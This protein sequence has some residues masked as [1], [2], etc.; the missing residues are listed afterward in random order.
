MSL[1]ETLRIPEASISNTTSIWGTPRGAGGIPSKINRPNVLLSAA[2][3]RS[4]WR[5][6]ISTEV[7][8]SAAVEKIWDLLVGIVVFLSIRGVITPPNV[9]RPRVRGVTSKSTTSLTSPVK[10]PPWIAAPM[11]TTSSGLTLRFGSL[12]KKLLTT[13]KTLGI[14]VIPP[15]MTIS[16]I[17]LMSFLASAKT[18]FT[19]AIVF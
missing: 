13:S 3:G 11:A 19:G 10:T 14:R 2:I 6:W 18:A 16:S 5:T 8:V 7:W 17:S 1:A 9:S 12:P 15:T 4:P